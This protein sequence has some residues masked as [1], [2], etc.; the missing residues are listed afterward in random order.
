MVDTDRLLELVPH[1]VA[2]LVLVSVILAVVRATVGELGFW[3][4]LAV[5]AVV[6]AAY[7]PVVTRLGYAPAAWQRQ[8]EEQNAGEE[9]VRERER[10]P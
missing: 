2:M 6:V 5:V 9:Q 1:Y 8:G 4:E 3:G 7:R 10:E